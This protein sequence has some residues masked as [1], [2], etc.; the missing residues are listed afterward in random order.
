MKQV[1]FWLVAALVLYWIVKAPSAAAHVVHGL[2]V[3]LAG[4]AHGLIAFFSAL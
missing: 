3:L 2:G 1:M 4:I